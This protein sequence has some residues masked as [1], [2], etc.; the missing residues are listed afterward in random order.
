MIRRYRLPD[1]FS[2]FTLHEE[3][4]P[5]Q[6]YSDVRYDIPSKRV[7]FNQAA[8]PN[9]NVVRVRFSNY[10]PPERRRFL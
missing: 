9:A 1:A 3:Y 2:D 6:P 5:E 4:E 8:R 10:Q 7:Y